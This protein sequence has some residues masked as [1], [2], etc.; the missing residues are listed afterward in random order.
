M[1]QEILK[2]GAG[3]LGESQIIAMPQEKPQGPFAFQ[4]PLEPRQ[5]PQPSTQVTNKDWRINS[6]LQG[7][8]EESA[9]VLG[10]SEDML[11]RTLFLDY[12]L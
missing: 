3:V 8:L 7:I 1:L 11:E 10:E 5:L 12:E 4:F 2:D 9:S 6:L